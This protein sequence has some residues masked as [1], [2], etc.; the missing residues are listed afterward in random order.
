MSLQV[1][2][3]LSVY[4]QMATN[5]MQATSQQLGA[6]NA[7]MLQV[8]Q[9]TTKHMTEN[10]IDPETADL[11]GYGP[12]M[13]VL[14]LDRNL[15]GNPLGDPLSVEPQPVA[16]APKA[17]EVKLK[18]ER[19]PRK[20][21]DPNAPKRPL[22]GYLMYYTESKDA[23]EKKLKST[24]GEVS[25]GRVQEEGKNLW[26]NMSEKEKEVNATADF[27]TLAAA[28]LIICS[29]SGRKSTRQSGK[30]TKRPSR[31]TLPRV[32]QSTPTHS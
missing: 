18:K 11:S 16:V 20:P 6:I 24:L 22:T 4:H 2:H 10:S 5:A 25:K 7:A 23:I 12:L 8:Q 32:E 9:A 31:S 3:A 15:I 26:N 1:A 30:S 13:R 14:S 17:P 27:V 21:K 28:K 29:R 19:K